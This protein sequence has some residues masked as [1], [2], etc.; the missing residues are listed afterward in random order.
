MSRAPVVPSSP[1]S[2]MPLSRD[3]MEGN[4]VD[5]GVPL[6]AGG[7]LS[8]SDPCVAQHHDQVRSHANRDSYSDDDNQLGG[9]SLRFDS[10]L[11][12]GVGEGADEES[13]EAHTEGDDLAAGFAEP[14]NHDDLGSSSDRHWTF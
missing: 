13:V 2:S 9:D 4:E 7:A 1:V 12:R 10:P 6:G 3:S 11:A 14:L 5:D 8:T